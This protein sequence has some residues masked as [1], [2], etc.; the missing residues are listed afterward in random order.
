M[1]CLPSICKNFP[2]LLFTF[3]VT[4]LSVT[5][6]SL[7]T[8][9]QNNNNSLCMRVYFLDNGQLMVMLILFPTVESQN[10]IG[11]IADRPPYYRQLADRPS[12]LLLLQI[13]PLDSIL[14]LFS[15]LN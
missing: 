6:L 11:L 3:N 7:F 8:H 12:I 15:H 9:T 4:Q 13:D 5:L 10:M 2:F 1:R 14:H